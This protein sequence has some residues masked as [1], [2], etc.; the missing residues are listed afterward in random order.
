MGLLSLSES[1]FSMPLELYSK[2]PINRGMWQSCYLDE[3]KVDKKALS[4]RTL[5]FLY[6]I[7]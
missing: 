5:G 6:K 3:G 1:I 2:P 4:V 7:N